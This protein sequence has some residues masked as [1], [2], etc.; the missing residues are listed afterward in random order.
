[1]KYDVLHALLKEKV[2]PAELEEAENLALEVLKENP[3]V[4]GTVFS[5]LRTHYKTTHTQKEPLITGLALVHCL[6]VGDLSRFTALAEETTRAD[7]ADVR[8]SPYVEYALQLADVLFQKKK[9][10]FEAADAPSPEF[11]PLLRT[12]NSAAAPK[13]K[14]GDEKEGERNPAICTKIAQCLENEF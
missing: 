12:I 11:L 14:H 10:G 7:K 2:P 4:Y 1:M 13:N 9:L 6:S 8:K 5:A 3:S